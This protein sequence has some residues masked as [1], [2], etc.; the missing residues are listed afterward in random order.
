[1]KNILKIIGIIVLLLALVNPMYYA[2]VGYHLEL[3][4]IKRE[5]KNKLIF[6]TPREELVTL[7]FELGGNEFKSLDWKHSSEFEFQ[8]KMFDIV[9][10]DTIGH[11]I[12]YLCFPDKQET[13]LNQEFDD[14]L[15]ERYANDQPSNNRQKLVNNF[16]KSLFVQDEEIETFFIAQNSIEYNQYFKEVIPSEY[17][18]ALDPPPQFI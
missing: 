11:F 14:L 9:E 15:N 7:K 10:A 16:I 4:K 8:G 12:Q 3:K 2:Y 13:A 17:I 5:V 6:D 18:K 1:M